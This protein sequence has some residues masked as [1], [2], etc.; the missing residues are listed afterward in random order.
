ME[1]T[2]S[3]DELAAFFGIS[4]ST[5]QDKCAPRANPQWPHLLVGGQL[6]FLDRHV[7]EIVALLERGTTTKTPATRPETA[8]VRQ[9]RSTRQP[10]P[11]T[12]GGFGDLT[13]LPIRTKRVAAS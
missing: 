5:V 2:I 3:R 8:P 1:P 4:P 10:G 6:R 12:S 7:E 11:A 13:P 9:R